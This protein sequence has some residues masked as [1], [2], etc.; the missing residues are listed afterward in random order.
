MAR[1]RLIFAA[2]LHF[3]NAIDICMAAIVCARTPEIEAIKLFA[4][5]FR[6]NKLMIYLQNIVWEKRA[7]T[8]FYNSRRSA[9][10]LFS[11]RVHVRKLCIFK[12]G[13]GCACVCRMVFIN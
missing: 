10:R 1:V 2:R 8:I 9:I 11:L 13:S 3:P 12:L 6:L 5:V 4:I 7:K